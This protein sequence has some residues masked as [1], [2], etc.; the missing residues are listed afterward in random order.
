MSR[1]TKEIASVVAKK[2]VAKK[3]KS[4]DEAGKKL[5]QTLTDMVILLIPKEVLEFN[6]K[7]PNYIDLTYA[8]NLEGNGWNYQ[9]IRLSEGLPFKCRAFMPSTKEAD[10][11]MKLFNEFKSREK[12]VIA[13]ESKIENLLYSLRTYNRVNAEFP[14]ATPFLPSI[15]ETGLSI[16]ISDIRNEL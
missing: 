11:L 3:A 7:H 6:K 9:R 8:L 2:L 4:R 13:L 15:K 1:I 5:E 12:H 14:E 10:I 16:N